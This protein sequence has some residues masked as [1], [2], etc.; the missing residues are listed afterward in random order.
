MKYILTIIIM[1]MSVNA[2]SQ[3]IELKQKPVLTH[4]AVKKLA[5]VAVHKAKLNGLNVSIAIVDEAGMLLYF[6]RMDGA[7]NASIRLSLAKAKSAVD[8]RTSG[9]KLYKAFKEGATIL[10]AIPGM[11]PLDGGYLLKTTNGSIIGA[12]GVS[13]S[14][15]ANDGRVAMEVV[16]YLNANQ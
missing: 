6:T 8:F 15:A 10:L 3:T 5:E 7:N 13:G 14:S 11:L 2:Y 16:N 4:K 1:F 9:K 12:I